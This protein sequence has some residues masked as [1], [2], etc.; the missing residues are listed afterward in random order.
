VG[1]PGNL[2]APAADRARHILDSGMPFVV[3]ERA[4]ARPGSSVL[5]TISGPPSFR[6]CVVVG[7]DGRGRPGEPRSH[8]TVTLAMDWETYL[9]LGAGRCRPADVDV[10]VQGDRDLADRVLGNMAMTP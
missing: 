9:R 4:G 7:E 6:S 1:R 3:A 10:S 8:P 5:F 2:D